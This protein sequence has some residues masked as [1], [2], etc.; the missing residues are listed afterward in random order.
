MLDAGLVEQVRPAEGADPLLEVSNLK[1]VF[2][3]DEGTVVAVDD[4]SFE[5]GTG[6]VFSIVGESG[7]GKSVTALSLMGL[8]GGGRGEIAEGRILFQ[9]RDLI[10]EGERRWRHLRGREMSMIFQDPMTSLNP[11]YTVGDQVA[12]V[13]R[14]HQDCTRAAAMESAIEM[15]ARV[16]IPNPR[17]RAHEYPHQFSGGM[18]Q[19]AMI[20]MAMIGQPRLLI[21]DEPTTA[22]DVTI[23]AQIL[24]LLADIRKDYGTSIILITHDLG[25]VAGF[26]D[27]VMVMYGGRVHEVGPTRD[28][29]YHSRGPYTWGLLDTIPRLDRD[30]GLDLKPIEGSAPSLITPPP[31]CRF[32]PRCPYAQEICRTTRPPLIGN[33]PDRHLTSCHFAGEEDWPDRR[34]TSTSSETTVRIGRK[35]G[36]EVLLEIDDLVK[37]IP[38]TGGMVFNRRVGYVKAVDGV[39][40][41]INKG[42]TF[43]LVGESGCGKTTMGRLIMRLLAPT[44]G[45]IRYAGHDVLRLKGGDLRSYRRKVQMVYQDPYASLNPRMRLRDI[46]AEPLRIHNEDTRAG[47]RRRVQYLLEVVGLDL[48]YGSRYPHE[49]SGGQRQRIG[50]A[51]ALALRPELL[52]L[53]EP[54]SALDVSIQAQILNLL[55]NLQKEFDLTYLIIAHDLAVVRHLSQRIGVMYLGRIVEMGDREEVYTRPTHPY[56]QALL[57][58]IPIP[59]PDREKG[60][61]L[62][63]L[64]GDPPSPSEPP[65]GC[66]FHPRCWKAEARCTAEIPGLEERTVNG[67]LSACHFADLLD[68]E[69]THK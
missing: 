64:A 26:S 37:H 17:R 19:R 66:T 41:T 61:I 24:E 43:G 69:A 49:L 54:V 50:I 4:V 15:L 14:I 47:I 29:Y 2:K 9:G 22:L 32:E 12:E 51:R 11:V 13:V 67:S 65:P 53:D 35:P 23:Q 25:V 55:S 1:T 40:L 46:I 42:E 6:E 27:R 52:I 10:A 7:S 60:R 68:S 48:S 34:E 30:P 18:R 45:R 38:I 62:R 63:R 3:T 44:G 31:G 21:A 5:V 39:S 8:I 20:A 59:D 16:G 36:S 57:S 33:R 28:I 56:S 58:A